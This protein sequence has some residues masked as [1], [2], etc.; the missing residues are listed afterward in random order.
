MTG[1]KFEPISDY[2]VGQLKLPLNIEEYGWAVAPQHTL[3][4]FV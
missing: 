1:L 3:F 2:K 4:Y